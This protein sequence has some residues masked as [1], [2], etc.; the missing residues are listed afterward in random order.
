MNE[1]S[2]QIRFYKSRLNWDTDI[3]LLGEGE[4]RNFLNTIPEES[5]GSRAN[6]PGTTLKTTLLS[7]A[8]TTN[9]TV[10][11]TE[12]ATGR[13]RFTF[14]LS[15]VPNYLWIEITLNSQLKH[16]Y[17]LGSGYSTVAT[18]ITHVIS[19]F[20]RLFSGSIY[21]Y[22]TVTGGCYFEFEYND[23]TEMYVRTGST[24]IYP[25]GLKVVG[26]YYNDLDDVSYF[27]V[28]DTTST[29]YL[30]QY[31]NYNDVL[32]ELPITSSI[33]KYTQV[34]GAFT[35]G[36]GKNT[37]LYWAYKDKTIHKINVYKCLTSAI[38]FTYDSTN[39][40]KPP[41]FSSLTIAQT[42]STS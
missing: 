29:H 18:F 11:T 17:V 4:S 1:I 37:L 24:A 42:N 19:E 31:V 27:W 21:T 35:I 13:K 40:L 3:S 22:G 14:T 34:T 41:P 25:S 2:Q 26:T 23:T 5:V 38:S 10:T 7:V 16:I 39:I 9:I 36:T 30:Y 6:C 28:Y 20:R 15:S 12:P 8:P 32:I 33:S